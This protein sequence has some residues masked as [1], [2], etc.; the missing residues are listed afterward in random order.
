MHEVHNDQPPPLP[1]KPSPSPVASLEQDTPPPLPPKN[2]APAPAPEVA[3]GGGSMFADM[4]VVQ[5]VPT[6]PTVIPAHAEPEVV[7]PRRPPTPDLHEQEVTRRPSTSST[8]S[9]TS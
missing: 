8:T 5:S 2:Q 1:P 7:P 9:S 3:V 6:Q 4:E